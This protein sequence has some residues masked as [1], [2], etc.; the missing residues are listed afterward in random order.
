MPSEKLKYTIRESERK[1]LLTG[2][3]PPF[4]HLYCDDKYVG[5]LG[6]D[7]TFAH[8]VLDLLNAENPPAPTAPKKKRGKAPKYTVMPP[9][10]QQVLP[11]YL[12]AI[13]G[14]RKHAF[15]SEEL[16]Q[17]VCDLL[18]AEEEGK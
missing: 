16:A 14:S 9:M 11:T 15:T 10:H 8:H 17:H 6:E 18:N 13:D 1:E 7:P 5:G 12:L 3:P 4:L 2:T